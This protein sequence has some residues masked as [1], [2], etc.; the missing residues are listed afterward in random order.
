MTQTSIRWLFIHTQ[1]WFSLPFHWKLCVISHN[2]KS[3]LTV[4]CLPLASS[5][6]YQLEATAWIYCSCTFCSICCYP[7]VRLAT[8]YDTHIT[9][10]SQAGNPANPGIGWQFHFLLHCSSYWHIQLL[11][12][13]SSCHSINFQYIHCYI[14]MSAADSFHCGFQRRILF[15]H[16][17]YARRMPVHI[18]MWSERL[19]SAWE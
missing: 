1:C 8:E 15:F 4:I 14:T 17:S 19:N 18:I 7:F 12:Q 9:G 10:S 16:H 11:L 3:I 13:L 6:N 2:I 5:A